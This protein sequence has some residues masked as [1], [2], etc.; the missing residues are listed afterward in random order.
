MSASSNASFTSSNLVLRIIASIFFIVVLVIY[1]F[2]S[3]TFLKKLIR[4]L[5]F[6]VMS[7]LVI[8]SAFSAL[9]VRNSQSEYE[10]GPFGALRFTVTLAKAGT[11]N[12][13][14]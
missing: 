13:Y 9:P 6:V 8:V 3:F 5:Y 4:S 10:I 11:E 14:L 7:E 12:E 1:M 2:Q